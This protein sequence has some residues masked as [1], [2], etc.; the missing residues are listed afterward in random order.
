MQFQFLMVQLKVVLNVGYLFEVIS[1]Q[2]L[3]VQLKVALRCN[4]SSLRMS[5]SIPYG[6]I[7]STY[8]RKGQ[9]K[10]QISIPY[11]SIKSKFQ[12]CVCLLLAQ[13]QFLMVQLK[14][15]LKYV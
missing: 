5:I 15:H 8:R 11:G 1:F 6:S 9:N 2:F 13:F 10:T 14:V 3:M 7:K 12:Q 4:N